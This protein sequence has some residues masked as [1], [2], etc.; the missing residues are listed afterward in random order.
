MN[1]KHDVHAQIIGIGFVLPTAGWDKIGSDEISIAGDILVMRPQSVD[2]NEQLSRMGDY[3]EQE[4]TAVLTNTQQEEMQRYNS[5]LNGDVLALMM[6][7]NDKVLVAGTR[8]APVRLSME[9]GGN[10]RTAKLTF[11]RK[12]P[13]WAKLMIEDV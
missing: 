3:V 11:K 7:T 12:S 10:P 4:L 8:R 13:E 9:V 6:L 2:F 1:N 5:W